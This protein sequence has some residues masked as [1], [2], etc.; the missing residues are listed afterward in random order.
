MRVSCH[1]H[2]SLPLSITAPQPQNAATD[3]GRYVAAEYHEIEISLFH[4][5]DF[6]LPLHIYYR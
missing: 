6:T 2:A 1:Y 4:R 5:R 3:V